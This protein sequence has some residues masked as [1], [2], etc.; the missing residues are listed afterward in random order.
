MFLSIWRT[1][2]AGFMGDKKS[3]WSRLLG[4]SR[5]RTTSSRNQAGDVRNLFK[6][7]GLDADQYKDFGAPQSVM[8]VEENRDEVFI[9]P[10]RIRS[11]SGRVT[12]KIKLPQS[13]ISDRVTTPAVQTKVVQPIEERKTTAPLSVGASS[14]VEKL[15]NLNGGRTVG[16]ALLKNWSDRETVKAQE[17]PLAPII[18]FASY[19][20]GVGKSTLAASLGAAFA[21]MG[22]R[23]LIVGQTAYSPL[24]YYFGGPR[25]LPSDGGA[26]IQQYSYTVPNASQPIDLMIGNVPTGELVQHAQARLTETSVVLMDMEASPHVE[27]DLPFFDMV[28]V[29]LRPDVNALVTIERIERVIESLDRRPPLGVWYLLNQFDATRDLHVQVHDVLRQRLGNRL[30]LFVIPLDNSVQEALANGQPPQIYRGYAPFA[31]AIEDFQVWLSDST[32]L[33]DGANPRSQV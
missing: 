33:T 28:I 19:T 4:G 15:G 10:T 32:K 30:L 23:P 17:T 22:I 5:N 6:D 3:I 14:S 31:K 24:A 7:L 25:T 1:G 26:T 11:E 12:E 2:G 29:P 13:N 27:E 21:Q 18:G 9:P 20:G 16:F 8:E